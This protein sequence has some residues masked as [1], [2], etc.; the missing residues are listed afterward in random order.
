MDLVI[1]G[2][3]IMNNKEH[4]EKVYGTKAPDAVSWYA[5]HLETSLNLIHQAIPDK[6]STIIDVG[7]GEATLVDDL[8]IKGYRNI[9]VLDIS[10]TAVDVAKSRVG[11][12]KKYVQWYCADIMSAKLPESYF[13]VWHD[14]AVFHFLTEPEKRMSYISQVLKSVKLGGHVIISTFGPEGPEKCSGLDVV[15]YDANELH[16]QFGKDFKLIKSSTEIHQTPF[17]T[18]QQ[19]LYCYCRLEK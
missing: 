3:V 10:Q 18:D 17:G 9:S 6:Q 5:P 14:R 13:D 15:R 4:W 2:M 12:A 7:G 1:M 16:D 8:L 11:D 19:F